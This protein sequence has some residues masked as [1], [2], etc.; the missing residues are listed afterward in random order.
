MSAIRQKRASN[1]RRAARRQG[2]LDVIT[3]DS[4]YPVD[5]FRRRTGIH[6]E[7][8]RLAKQHGVILN[9]LHVGRRVFVRGSDAIQFIED[10]AELTAKLQA[11]DLRNQ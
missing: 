7:R 1:T 2:E 9:K 8:E 3:P 11:D 6:R 10:L 4:M 5:T